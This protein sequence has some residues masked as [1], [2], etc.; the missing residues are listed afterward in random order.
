[1]RWIGAKR[2]GIRGRRR[3]P[4]ANERKRKPLAQPE[5]LY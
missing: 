3:Y 2:A 4:P 1:L 5:D